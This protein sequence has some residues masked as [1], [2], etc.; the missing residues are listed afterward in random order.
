[1]LTTLTSGWLTMSQLR[2]ATMSLVQQKRPPAPRTLTATIFASGATP[3]GETRPS[4]VTMPATFDPCPLSSSADPGPNAVE[5]PPRQQVCEQKQ[6]SA[7]RSPPR[8][9]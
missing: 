9:G 2:P 6:A 8:S 4:D 5:T 7:T 3:T 1:M